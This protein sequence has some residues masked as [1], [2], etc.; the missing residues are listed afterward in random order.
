MQ[1]LWTTFIK[2]VKLSYQGIY[3][4]MEVGMAIIFILV[5][6][7]AV[8]ENFDRTQTFYGFV[9]IESIRG[10]LTETIFDSEGYHIEL[11]ESRDALEEALS[12]NRSAVGAHIFMDGDKPVIDLVL[13]G[14]ESESMKAFLRSTIEGEF[15]S[16]LPDYED[17]TTLTALEQAPVRLSDRANMLPIYLV[18]NVAFMGLFIIAAYVFLDKEEGVIKAFAVAPVKVW[19]YLVSKIMIMALMGVLI[20][21]IVVISLIGFGVNYPLLILVILIYSVFGSTL[22]LLITSFFDSMTKAMGAL[23]FSIFVLMFGGFSYFIPS[24]SPIWLR[25]LPSYPMIFSFRELLME[26]GDIGYVFQN[27][28]I[29][30]VLTAVLFVYTNHRFKKTLTV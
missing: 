4:Y 14:H 28:G 27:I 21:T 7:F 19:H 18:M 15:M 20:S 22:G 17:R 3:F 16:Q 11:F 29:F 13:Q 23:F 8:P 25:F 2:D 30:T 10:E 26:N 6:L 1:K 12:K 24:F 5:M 9:E